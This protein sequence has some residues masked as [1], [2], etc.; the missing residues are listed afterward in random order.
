MPRVWTALLFAAI[1][2]V[3]LYYGGY[4]WAVLAAILGLRMVWEWVNMSDPDASGIALFIPMTGL[5][6]TLGYT[7]QSDIGLAALSAIITA[8]ICAVE[9][10][11]RGAVHWAGLGALYI[12]VPSAAMIALRGAETGLGARGFQQI[13]FIILI[14]VAADTAAYFGG[15]YF[16]GPKMAPKLS[17]NKTWSGFTSGL[18]FATIIGVI[19]GVIMGLAWWHAALLAIPTIIISVCGDFAESAMKRRLNVKDAGDVLPGHGGVLDRLDALMA[20]VVFAAI[21]L[22]LFP[23]IWPI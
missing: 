21:M 17:P 5:I 3:P 16:K 2:I 13:L 23:Q 9:R 20:S 22:V 14:V 18:V 11:R 8:V 1:C 15:S 4:G 19:A 12:I 10:S 6:I 7:V